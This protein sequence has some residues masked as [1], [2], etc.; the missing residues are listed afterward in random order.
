MIVSTEDPNG[1]EKM[2]GQSSE[3]DADFGVLLAD[4]DL[5]PDA[6]S[7]NERVLWLLSRDLE[8]VS[9]GQSL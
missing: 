6:E 3:V 2:A 8:H 5:D 9:A 4:L 1:I 7:L